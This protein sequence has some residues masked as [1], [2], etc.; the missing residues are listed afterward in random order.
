MESVWSVS[1]LSTE[2]VGSLRQLVAMCSH[3]RRRCDKTVSSR[4]RCVLGLS[5]LKPSPA[6]EVRR[7]YL[8]HYATASRP[9]LCPSICDVEV[10][11]YIVCV[12]SKIFTCIIFRTAS[13]LWEARHPH[14]QSTSKGNF[15][16]FQVEL[17]WA[18]DKGVLRP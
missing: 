17:E 2:S 8:L 1:K 6:L 13:F 15:P 12:N 11:W 3:R 16:K 7:E 14:C 4:R 18:I 10:L 9:S 5:K